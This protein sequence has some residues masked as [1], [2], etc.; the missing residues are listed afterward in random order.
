MASLHLL[1]RVD[2]YSSNISVLK[3]YKYHVCSALL[4]M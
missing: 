4:V 3:L 2:I 1:Q